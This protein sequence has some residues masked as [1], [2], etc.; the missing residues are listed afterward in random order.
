VPRPRRNVSRSNGHAI[1]VRGIPPMVHQAFKSY[2][3]RRNISMM[4]AIVFLMAKCVQRGIRLEIYNGH[5]PETGADFSPTAAEARATNE[6]RAKVSRGLQR[7]ADPRVAAVLNTR[8]G[9]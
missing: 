1:N 3:H 4:D 9:V 6:E 7:A 5:P 2:C 8:M